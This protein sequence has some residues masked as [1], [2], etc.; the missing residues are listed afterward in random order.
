MEK[1]DLVELS[2]VRWLLGQLLLLVALLGGYT[3]DL[4]SWWLVSVGLVATLGSLL[5]PG[6]VSRMPELYRKAGPYLLLGVI[7]MDFVISGS[8]FLPPLYRMLLWLAIYR[9]LQER[10]AREELQQLALVLFLVL[11]T[12]VLSLEISFALQLLVL[13]PLGMGLLFAVN[14]GHREGVGG[15][16]AAVERPTLRE[17]RWGRLVR[18]VRGRLDGRTLLAGGGLLAGMVMTTALLF[19]LLPRFEI[20]QSLPFPQLKSGESLSGFSDH[21]RYGDVVRILEDD[22]MAMRV[23]VPADKPVARP[24]WRM[25]VLDAYYDGGF[26]VSEGL[27]ESRR[28]MQHHRFR[29]GWVPRGEEEEPWTV[30]L[31][32]GVSAYLPTSSRF[33]RLLFNNQQKLRVDEKTR[34]LRLAEIPASTLSMRYEGVDF[35]VEIPA[36]K[37]DGILGEMEPLRVNTESMDAVAEMVY[38]ETLMAVPEGEAN[39]RIVAGALERAGVEAVEDPVEQVEALAAWLREGRGYSL[40]TRIPGGEADRVLRWLESEQ[41][42]HCE[43]YAG[44]YA[45]LAR[46]A[47]FPTRV[48]TGFA[49]GDWNGFENYFMVRNRHAHAW[50]ESWIAGVGW[51]RLD[52]TPGS[53]GGS[54]TVEQALAEGN[55]FMDRTL[56]AYVDSLR[57]LWFRRVIQFDEED[58]EALGTQ[59]RHWGAAFWEL[60]KE[61]AWAGLDWLR[62]TLAGLNDGEGRLKSVRDL[63]VVVGV[64]L[65]VLVLL[66]KW[67]RRWRRRSW[68]ERLRRQAGRMLRR[69]QGGEQSAERVALLERVRYGAVE[70]W[71][72]EPERELRARKR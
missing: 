10:S 69:S 32:G 27:R 54:G 15:N 42:G 26:V 23:D 41:A 55:L 33:S 62:S 31:A 67:G 30:Y 43:L 63:S 28:R 1:L 72:E 39:E 71:P 46:A 49:G 5:W 18:R 61:N 66:V 45:L 7:G 21:I 9:A 11:L 25:V 13:T 3:V 2:Q 35:G 6:L 68:E 53:G 37:A 19:L 34:V 4:D 59:A 48:V 38:P 52:P 8:D 57:I 60:L 65:G 36:T 47:G 51:L 70:S 56:A 22:Q 24:Y 44:A 12:G 64:T 50:C 17:V 58:Q 40:E 20:G 16:E 29:F 14:L